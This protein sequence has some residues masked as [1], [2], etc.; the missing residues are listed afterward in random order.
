[1]FVRGAAN[2][3]EVCNPSNTASK[4]A[5]SAVVG[6]FDSCGGSILCVDRR[7]PSRAI[8][9]TLRCMIRSTT[10]RVRLENRLRPNGRTGIGNRSSVPVRR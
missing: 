4:W 5:K 6:V 9:D 2:G 3:D 10:M 8:V 7:R 1:M